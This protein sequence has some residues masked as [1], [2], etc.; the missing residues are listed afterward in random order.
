M[1]SIIQL[2]DEKTTNRWR[3][4]LASMLLMFQILLFMASI[5]MVYNDIENIWLKNIDPFIVVDAI[6]QLGQK[7]IIKSERSC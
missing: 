5:V 1:H 6:L 2:V 4:H 7:Q 3:E